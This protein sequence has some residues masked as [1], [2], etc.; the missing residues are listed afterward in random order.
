MHHPRLPDFFISNGVNIVAPSDTIQSGI[1][2][3]NSAEYLKVVEGTTNVIEETGESIF[4]DENQVGITH[5]ILLKIR[6]TVFQ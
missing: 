6:T 3:E 1:F 4:I 5:P 2:H